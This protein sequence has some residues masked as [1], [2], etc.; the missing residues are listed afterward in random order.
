MFL[1]LKFLVV[2]MFEV[3]LVFYINFE[4]MIGMNEEEDR[5][6]KVLGF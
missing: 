2:C 6:D 1:V 5:S 4:N 3:W